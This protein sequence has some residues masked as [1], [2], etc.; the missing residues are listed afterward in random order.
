MLV[1]V[2]VPAIAAAQS[3][4]VER[5]T[6]QELVPSAGA[7]WLTGGGNLSNTRYSTLADINTTNVTNMQGAWLT[8]LGSGRGAQY[9]FEAEPLVIDGVMY[10]ST[11]NDDVFALDAKTGQKLW[12]SDARLDPGISTV[13][14]EWV[15]HGVAVGDGLVFIGRLDGGVAALD[16]AT[17]AVAW[18]T[19]LEQWQDGYSIVSTPRYYD[20][21]VYTGMSGGEY[22]GRG[23]LYALDARTGQEVWRFYTASDPNQV[24]GS[25]W[26]ADAYQHGGGAVWQTPALDPDLG[27]LYFS[28]GGPAPSFDGSGRPGDNLFASSIVAVDYKTGQ[29]RWHFQEVHHDIWGYGAPS[30]V[31]LFDT[32]L[33]GEPRKALYQAGNTGWLYL[34]DRTDGQPLLGITERPVPQETS[35]ATASTQP[36]PLGD[37]FSPQ[38]GEAVASIATGCLFDPFWDAARLIQPGAQGGPAWAATAFS[39]VAGVVYVNALGLAGAFKAQP[40]PLTPGQMYRGGTAAPPTGSSYSRTLTALDSHTNR[41]VWQKQGDGDQNYGALVTAGDLLVTGQVDGNLVA[42]NA[43]TGDQLWTFQTGLGITAPPITWEMDGTQ[44]VTIVAGGNS[45]SG[46]P[47]QDGDAVWTFRLAGG[48]DEMTSPPPPQ[49]K[50]GVPP[51]IDAPAPFDSIY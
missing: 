22:G 34:L 7:E 51:S 44:Y 46:P 24:G 17:G 32:Q 10:L 37:A 27:L 21:L 47:S 4:P 25:T 35:Q 31:V 45:R 23:R 33:N 19:Q 8:R 39:P 6:N 15:N 49:T 2:P 42:Y 43:R 36:Y 16:R 5:P 29:Y 14:C 12:E 11:G 30:P 28:T 13:C 41:I 9:R 20:G 26:Q 40:G 48:I 38:C 1:C 3:D 50:V 18:Q